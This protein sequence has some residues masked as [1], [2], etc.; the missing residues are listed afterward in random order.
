[1]VGWEDETVPAGAFHTLKIEA[2]GTAEGRVATAA[3]VVSGAVANSSGATTISHV[4]RPHAG[5]V[6]VITYAAFYYAPEIKYFVK[7][8]DEQYNSDNVRT[9]RDT[10]ALVSFKPQS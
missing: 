2:N 6:H 9:S 10:W 5:V 4:E 7:S 8:I 1:M 3:S